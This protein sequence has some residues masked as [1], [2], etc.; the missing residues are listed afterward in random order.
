MCTRSRAV[1]AIHA[2]NLPEYIRFILTTYV[3]GYAPHSAEQI[4]RVRAEY[5]AAREEVRA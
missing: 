1:L 5:I 4:E 3:A 2:T